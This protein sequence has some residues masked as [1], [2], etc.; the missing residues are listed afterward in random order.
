MTQILQTMMLQPVPGARHVAFKY[1]LRGVAATML[2]GGRTDR[3]IEVAVLQQDH[4]WVSVSLRQNIQQVGPVF[5]RLRVAYSHRILVSRYVK[6]HKKGVSDVEWRRGLCVYPCALG[7]D[8]A[9]P[10][11]NPPHRGGRAAR[12]DNLQRIPGL[13]FLCPAGLSAGANLTRSRMASSE[14]SGL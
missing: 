4:T 7:K 8:G 14:E 6:S 12:G 5:P 2:H 13:D 11:A 10:G 3:L 9:A 1:S